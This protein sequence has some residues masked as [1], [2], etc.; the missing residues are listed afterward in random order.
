MKIDISELMLKNDCFVNTVGYYKIGQTNVLRCQLDTDRRQITILLK[1]DTQKPYT[2]PVENAI[3]Y[4]F[5]DTKSK[6]VQ[7]A[8]NK[9]EKKSS[10]FEVDNLDQ[11]PGE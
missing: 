3:Y 5:A 6:A 2:L 1:G 8:A 9:P 11:Y 7:K 10:K 4:R